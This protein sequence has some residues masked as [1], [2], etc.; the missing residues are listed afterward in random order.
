M[1]LC[2]ASVCLIH[3]ALDSKYSFELDKTRMDLHIQ[4]THFSCFC[5]CTSLSFIR[6]MFRKFLSKYVETAIV[7]PQHSSMKS[8]AEANSSNPG[9]PPSVPRLQLQVKYPALDADEEIL[10]LISE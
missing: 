1:I 9:K 7:S 10:K 8:I 2:V 4:L 6:I 3:K 5:Y